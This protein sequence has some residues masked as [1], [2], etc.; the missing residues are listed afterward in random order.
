MPYKTIYDLNGNPVQLVYIDSEVCCM[1]CDA[2][3]PS[4]VFFGVAEAVHGKNIP[5]S[6]ALS[7]WEIWIIDSIGN[8]FFANGVGGYM[9]LV[10]NNRASYF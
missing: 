1:V 2:A 6:F 8:K 7:V 3:D 5:A 10:W 9:D 4:R